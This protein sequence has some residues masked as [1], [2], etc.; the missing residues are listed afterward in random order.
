MNFEIEDM[1]SK[2]IIQSLRDKLR[3][4]IEIDYKEACYELLKVLHTENKKVVI[5]NQRI[6]ELTK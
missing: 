3:D 2:I 4:N 5:L 1:R 6:S